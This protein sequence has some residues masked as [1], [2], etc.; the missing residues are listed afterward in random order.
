M[1]HNRGVIKASV[2]AQGAA[3][4][5]GVLVLMSSAG[6][7]SVIDVWRRRAGPWYARAPWG[8]GLIT[9][10][11]LY[12]TTANVIEKPD[13]IKIAAFFIAAIL[14]T[15]FWSRFAR[16]RE[17]RRV[18]AVSVAPGF[19]AHSETLLRRSGRVRTRRRARMRGEQRP[20]EDLDGAVDIGSGVRGAEEARLEL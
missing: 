17:L 8:F 1:D 20:G 5:T 7:A 14:L 10:V 13:C 18:G 11:F 12:P 6:V 2:E 15:S 16:S 9:L 4:A 19:P 3:Y